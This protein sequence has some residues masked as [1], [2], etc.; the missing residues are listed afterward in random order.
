MIKFNETILKKT[1]KT[2]RQRVKEG[3]KPLKTIELKDTNGKL[4][5]LSITQYYGLYQQRALYAFKHGKYPKYTTLNSRCSTLPIVMNY[6]DNSYTCCPTS[7]SMASMCL[8]GARSE[9]KCA[10]VLGTVYGSGT[11]PYQLVTNA[12][13]L[14][15]TA[16]PIGRN[17]QSVLKQLQLGRPIIAHIQTKNASCLGFQNDYGHYVLIY[18]CKGGYYHVADPTKGLHKC[19]ST[20]LDHATNGRDIK[21]YSIAPK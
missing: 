3:K 2:L 4:H 8:F 12:P 16:T 17:Y 6:Q 20:V 11:S 18:W 5:K 21:Y 9:K 15:Y 13:K 7:L 14:G 1:G 10:E 19:K